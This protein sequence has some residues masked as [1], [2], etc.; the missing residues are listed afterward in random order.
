MTTP[1][2]SSPLISSNENNF[3]VIVVGAGP[4]G[5]TCAWKLAEQ[6]AR[7]LLLER[8]PTL[9]RYKP[10]G[11]GIPAS[12]AQHVSGL[13]PTVFADLSVTH[14]RHS[15]KGRDPVLAA[16]E[17][18]SG[19]PATVW[20]VQRPRFDRHLVDRAVDAGATLQVGVKVSA[21][22][23]DE[24]GVTVGSANG[25]RFRARHVVGADGAK[26]VV[27]ARVGLRLNKRWGMAR[28]IELPF[29]GGANDN[30]WHPGLA[31]GAAYLDYG[32]VKNGYAWIFPKRGCLSVGAGML[33][34]RQPSTARAENGVGVMLRR[35]I[36]VL[37]DSV[38][39]P[40]PL[41]ED[42]PKLWAHPIPFW[43]GSE[44]L[45]TNDGRVLLV[46]DAAGVVQPL[47]GEGI[48][49][50]LRTGDLAARCLLAG[51][52]N[53]YTDRVRAALAPEF[54]AAG[55]VGRVF[56]RAPL[57]SYRLGVKNPA[58]TRL[59][60]R[61]MAGEASLAHLEQRIYERLRNPLRR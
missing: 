12:V 9:P 31:P 34:P 49:Y 39:L 13:D 2:I 58:G 21:I 23:V 50:A 27:G 35:A 60:G 55:R 19:A 47:F 61:L 48:Q 36:D 44:P 59:V 37:L 8:A 16:M 29:T 22:D 53:A 10:C 42:A 54:D 25:Q 46:G 11:G 26:G 1:P 32:S 57:L 52:A 20:M 17:T 3:E 51:K 40:Y 41:G 43:T 4:G 7:V 6:G 38:G 14:L 30:R 45:A 24:N 28:E 33:M 15:W 5:A 56:H 18:T